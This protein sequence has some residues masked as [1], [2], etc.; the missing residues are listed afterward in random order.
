[1][2]QDVCFYFLS[3]IMTNLVNDVN[4]YADEEKNYINVVVDIPAGSHNKYEYDHELWCFKLDRVIHHSMFYPCEYGFVPQTICG[5]GD[6]LDVCL[7]T[8]DPTFTGCVIKARPIGI[9]YTAD[10]DG[11]DPKIVAVP[12]PKVDPR[13]DE[14]ETIDDLGHHKK[15]E[16]SILFK[17]IKHLEK[18]KYDKVIFKW[19]GSVEDAIAEIKASRQRFLEWK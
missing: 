8:T 2:V 13:R 15:E 5:D 18:A 17:E 11:D 6:P 3:F 12:I 7:F 10:Q 1:M 16:L 19:F 4:T 14:V 9:L